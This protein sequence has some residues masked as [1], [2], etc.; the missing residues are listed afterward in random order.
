MEHSTP[1]A[2]A[3]AAARS[4]LLLLCL[5]VAA[6]T[7]GVLQ[8]RAQPDSNGMPS[9]SLG[10]P[11]HHC[12]V[13]GITAQCDAHHARL[14]S[15]GS[16]VRFHQRRLR[17]ARDGELRRRHHQAGV[18]PGRRLHRRRLQPQHLGRVHHADARQALPQRAQLPRRR[19]QLLH[20]P[21]HRRRAQVPPPRHLQVRQLRRPRPA[22]HLRPL[23]RRQL[24]D[25]RERHGRRLRHHPRGHRPRAG[26]STRR[27]MRR[28][29][30]SSTTGS[31]SARPIPPRSSG[32]TKTIIRV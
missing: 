10:L 31:T 5:A 16:A 32:E 18:R 1:R 28:R 25:H 19:A 2:M 11:F 12:I 4:R 9:K 6:A 8:A 22:A 3:P 27:R 20:A 30:W 14:T 24:L 7:A 17:P 13:N 26:R 15:W 29:A 21:L 23:H